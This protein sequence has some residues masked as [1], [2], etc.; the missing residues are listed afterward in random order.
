MYGRHNALR[1]AARRCSH[2]GWNVFALA[3]TLVHLLSVVGIALQAVNVIVCLVEPVREPL[4]VITIA[5]VLSTVGVHIPIMTVCL[6]LYQG[7]RK[8]LPSALC[9]TRGNICK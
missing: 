4:V 8:L 1:R 7:L 3:E 9:P 5:R 2:N 6:R